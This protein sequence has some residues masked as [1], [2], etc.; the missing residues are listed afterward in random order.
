MCLSVCAAVESFTL[1]TLSVFSHLKLRLWME[2]IV[3]T[4]VVRLTEHS[5][6]TG[7]SS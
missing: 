5:G 6:L 3:E 1:A 7:G 4:Y 2:M